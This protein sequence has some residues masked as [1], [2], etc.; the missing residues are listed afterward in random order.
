MRTVDGER[1]L[2]IV[3]LTI[4]LCLTGPPGLL[5]AAVGYAPLTACCQT[6]A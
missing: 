1:S 5:Q 4:R 2:Q 3:L 6:W